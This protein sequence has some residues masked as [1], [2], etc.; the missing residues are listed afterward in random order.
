MKSYNSTVNAAEM[1]TIHYLLDC[2]KFYHPPGRLGY[3]LKSVD[4]DWIR[5]AAIPP[6]DERGAFTGKTTWHKTLDEAIAALPLKKLRGGR[7]SRSKIKN[8]E[9]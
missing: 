2:H 7:S 9:S 4:P 1:A 5:F 8:L 6:L 3:V